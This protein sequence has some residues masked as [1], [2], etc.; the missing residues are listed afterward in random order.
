MAGQ[1]SDAEF[2]AEFLRTQSSD[3]GF[4][5]TRLATLAVVFFF[6]ARAVVNGARAPSLVLPLVVEYVSILW[7]GLFL[8]IFVVDCPRFR[9]EGRRP[10]R[11]VLWTAFLFVCMSALLAWDHGQLDVAG[12]KAGWV[13]TWSDIWSTGVIWAM[14]AEIVGLLVSSVREIL[15]WRQRG[16]V[17]VWNS[18]FGA[19]LRIAVVMMLA[20][21]SPFIVIPLADSL[22]PWLLET[23]TRLAWTA[24]GFLV[25]VELGGLAVGVGLHR[26]IQEEERKKAK[27]DEATG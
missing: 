12:A 22:I 25:F 14:L 8:S 20:I 26:S 1:Y 16:G 15:E 9:A 7:V 6:L 24:F 2:D 3:T 5:V 18:I 4:I 17:F 23:P 21:F 13:S 11:I 10:V 19:S 27:S